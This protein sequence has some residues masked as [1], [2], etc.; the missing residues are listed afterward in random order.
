MV[1]SASCTLYCTGNV[2]ESLRIH[3]CSQNEGGWWVAVGPQHNISHIRRPVNS[4]LWRSHPDDVHQIIIRQSAH[5]SSVRWLASCEL[6]SNKQLHTPPGTVPTS[7]HSVTQHAV[8]AVWKT[9][10]KGQQQR[11][12]GQGPLDQQ[13]WFSTWLFCNSVG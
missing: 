1:G 12:H 10:T 2:L 4:Q 3:L 7:S 8:S 6:I 9:T 5:S 13:C 11:P